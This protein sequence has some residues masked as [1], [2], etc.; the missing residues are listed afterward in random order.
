MG[1]P[2]KGACG[3]AAPELLPPALPTGCDCDVALRCPAAA[4]LGVLVPRA[5]EAADAELEVGAAA[6]AADD[7]PDDGMFVWKTSMFMWTLSAGP[8]PSA[9]WK[10]NGE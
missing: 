7:A 1:K 8:F 3:P 2:G 10:Q 4:W 9:V 6:L 5:L